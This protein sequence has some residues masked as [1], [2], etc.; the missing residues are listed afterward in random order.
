MQE[1]GKFMRLI[2]DL[3]GT[4]IDS[5]PDL[6]RAANRMLAEMFGAGPVPVETFATFIGNGIPKQV[7]RSLRHAG[8]EADAATVERAVETFKRFFRE[9][10]AEGTIVFDGVREALS[11]LKE[12]GAKMA[13]CTNKSE[14]LAWLTLEH[15][16]MAHLFDAL[17]GG[18]T[19]PVKKPHPEPLHECARR[20]G[21]NAGPVFYVGDSETD[22]EAA[23][24]AGYPLLLYTQGYRKKPVE[25][26][27]AA[28]TFDHFRELPALL[29]QIA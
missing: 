19:L 14:D 29:K 1:T 4:L 15:L 3:D 9:A 2:F 22:E 8:I 28:G 10:P 11:E 7:T 21:E 26:F 16:G 20:L 18:E 25:T 24:A 6:N 23:H 13:V 5:A 17:T 12:A 27:D